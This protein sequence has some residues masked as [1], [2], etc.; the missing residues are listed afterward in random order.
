MSEPAAP[1]RLDAPVILLGRGGSGTRLLTALARPLG[2][3]LGALVEATG[4]S[5]D[6]VDVLYGLALEELTGELVPYS[7]RDLYWRD[8]LREV[9]A[10]VLAQEDCGPDARWGWKLPETMLVLAP[11]LRAFP[12]ARIVHLV[13]HPV[14][15]SLRR[16][17]LTSRTDT[18][19]GRAALAMAYRAH[20]LPADQIERDEPYLHNALSWNFQLR[21]VLAVLDTARPPVLTLRYE[22][23]CTQPE[24]AQREVAAFLETDSPAAQPLQTDRARMNGAA[25]CDTRAERVWSICR[26]TA[27]LLDYEFDSIN[28]GCSQS[29]E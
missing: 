8:R 26:E 1:S 9:G 16:T 3:H 24:T 20:G 15:S 25:A 27:E 12:Q 7:P 18:D 10:G 14:T 5:K 23:V 11:V 21:S 17:H 22:E 2:V 19:V 13:R 6:W 29:A 4:D 28:S